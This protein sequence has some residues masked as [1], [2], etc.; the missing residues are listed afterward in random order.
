MLHKVSLVRQDIRKT[1]F[2]TFGTPIENSS[3]YRLIMEAHLRQG[4]DDEF[5]F[6]GLVEASKALILPHPVRG[7][8]L[9]I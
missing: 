3:L 7:L 4:N 8:N 6:G 1:F 5:L 9:F 2:K